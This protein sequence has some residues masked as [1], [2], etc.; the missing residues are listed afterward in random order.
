MDYPP[1]INDGTLTNLHNEWIEVGNGH[2]SD[3]TLS[4]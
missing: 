4:S 1:H 3:P 2:V